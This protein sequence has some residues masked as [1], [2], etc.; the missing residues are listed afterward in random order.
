MITLPTPSLA[1][2]SCLLQQYQEF[3]VLFMSECG[4]GV[5][6]FSKHRRYFPSRAITAPN[7]H[8]A[9]CWANNLA[10]FLKIRI[11]GYNGKAVLQRMAPDRLI[12]GAIQS[13]RLDMR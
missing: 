1:G 5:R 3:R 8:H 4:N 7:P 13:C 12:V 2:H 6:V 11:L 10:A 9:R